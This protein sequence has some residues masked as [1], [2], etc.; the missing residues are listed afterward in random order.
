MKPYL[1]SLAALRGT[2]AGLLAAAISFSAP[3]P[4]GANEAHLAP[5]GGSVEQARTTFWLSG[6]GGWNHRLDL[7]AT[8]L[9]GQDHGGTARLSIT[10]ESCR[11]KSPCEQSRRFVRDLG[12][13]EFSLEPGLMGATLTTVFAGRPLDLSWTREPT[14]EPGAWSD[15]SAGTIVLG[16]GGEAA[17]SGSILGLQCAGTGNFAHHVEARLNGLPRMSGG[18]DP[19]RLSLRGVTSK[20]SCGDVKRTRGPARRETGFYELPDNALG[21]HGAGD[22]WT[23]EPT[24]RFLSIEINDE[25]GE[26][27]YALVGFDTDGDRR[28]DEFHPVCGRSDH[29][30]RITGRLLVVEIHGGPCLFPRLR[31]AQATWGSFQL[32]FSEVP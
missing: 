14:D 8:R 2:I 26:L 24:E 10:I 12:P 23:V 1:P 11:R 30:I 21:I 16:P 32:T 27:V 25:S 6:K 19:K 5:W 4:V 3:P 18:S 29:P 17:V 20:V 7:E 15:I 22:V 31:P 28:T 9:V 13:D